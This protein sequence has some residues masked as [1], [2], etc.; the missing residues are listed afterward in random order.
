MPTPFPWRAACIALGCATAA[1]AATTATA[2]TAPQTTSCRFTLECIEGEPCAETDYAVQI[3]ADP[4]RENGLILSTSSEELN[5][6]GIRKN[7]PG[8]VIFPGD[9][10]MHLITSAANGD[11][12]YTIHMQGPMVISY[13]GTCEVID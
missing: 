10:A 6:T 9:T 1:T 11:A 2:Q 7:G 8:H 4:A 5:G 3:L 12:R 13:Q